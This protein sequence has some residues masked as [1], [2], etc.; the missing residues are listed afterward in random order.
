M[1]DRGG[2]ARPGSPWSC[3]RSGLGRPP[4][5]RPAALP[6]PIEPGR[7]SSKEAVERLRDGA[8]AA[9]S[10]DAIGFGRAL[11]ETARRIEALVET[12]KRF[13]LRS[14]T[15]SGER[16]RGLDA[17]AD[18]GPQG[19][20]PDADLAVL[21]RVG[22]RLRGGT[23]VEPRSRAASRGASGRGRGAGLRRP[24]DGHGAATG[25][26]SADDRLRS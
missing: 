1:H 7:S 25:A 15:R 17:R 20:S 14:A 26:R 5:S 3:R 10:G 9:G 24:C 4:H 11:T 22:Y 13:P 19:Y 16:P 12:A 8:K 18:V 2:R 21:D 23:S 6:T